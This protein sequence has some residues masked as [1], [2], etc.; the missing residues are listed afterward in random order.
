GREGQKVTTNDNLAV[1]LDPDD[2][3]ARIRTG[4]E[5]GIERTIRIQP[6]EIPPV[7]I[8]LGRAHRLDRGEGTAHENLAILLQGQRAHIASIE[9]RAE[10]RIDRAVRIEPRHPDA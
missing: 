3:D 7:L 9:F 4:I 6:D 10:V 2:R 5:A 8:L 1:T